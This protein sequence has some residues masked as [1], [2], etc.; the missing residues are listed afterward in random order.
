[1]C[2][3]LA[4]SAAPVWKIVERLGARFAELHEGRHDGCPVILRNHDPAFVD[5]SRE[6]VFRHEFSRSDWLDLA[7]R[8]LRFEDWQTVRNQENRVLDANFESAVDAVISGDVVHL[9]RLLR[10]QPELVSARSGWGHEAMLL[11]YV[12]ANGV[13]IHRQFVPPNIMKVTAMLLDAGSDPD[14][15]CKTYGGGPAD[16]TLCLLISS[17]HPGDLGVK[18]PL[19]ELLLDR[20]ASLDGVG[21]GGDPLRTAVMFGLPD[22]SEL[23]VRRGANPPD[24][25]TAAGAGVAEA[26]ARFLSAGSKGAEVDEALY[27]SARNGYLEIVERLLDHGAE[28]DAPG[29]FGATPLLWAAYEGHLSITKTLIK[30]GADP[31]RRDAR[32]KASAAGWANESGNVEIR[33]WLIENGCHA[34]IVEAAAFGRI[35][36]VRRHLLEDPERVDAREGRTALHEAAGRGFAELVE[37]L[38]NHGAQV[39]AKDRNGQT[40][41][42]WAK[43]H[44]RDEIIAMLE[45]F[46]G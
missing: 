10:E 31:N 4:E 13:E 16:T 36:L 45:P 15:L 24:L 34:S 11:H 8:Y 39:G 26:V 41:L 12:A 28:V 25:K 37:L 3:K 35:D 42:D 43:R 6:E 7:A 17:G 29:L 18:E 38:L 1:M 30:R 2:S 23:L 22:I 46:G 40:P 20:G 19:V 21:G 44:H 5:T 33:D 14:A 32:F 9:R 27:L